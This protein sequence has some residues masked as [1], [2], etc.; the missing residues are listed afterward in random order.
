[1]YANNG[2]RTVSDAYISSHSSFITFAS[3]LT[4]HPPPPSL[5][6]ILTILKLIIAWYKEAI[7]SIVTDCIRWVREHV[8]NVRKAA[9]VA[10]G[11]TLLYVSN[12][13]H[14]LETHLRL[15]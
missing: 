11:G 13:D 1:V 5:C 14:E 12:M 4:F 3:G 10:A 9:F 8:G 7:F 6:T 2:E 15:V